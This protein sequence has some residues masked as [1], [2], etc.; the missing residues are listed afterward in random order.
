[1]GSFA[2]RNDEGVGA[3]DN[4]ENGRRVEKELL[5]KR[6]VFC[7][8]TDFSEILHVITRPYESSNNRNPMTISLPVIM[9]SASKNDHFRILIFIVLLKIN[10][11]ISRMV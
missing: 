4:S 9:E 7:P 2:C 8:L 10:S 5:R 3:A 6:A 11:D 1:M